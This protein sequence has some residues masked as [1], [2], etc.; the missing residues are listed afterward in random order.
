MKTVPEN[1]TGYL[2]NDY[3]AWTVSWNVTPPVY[4][5]AS[6][7]LAKHRHPN[8]TDTATLWNIAATEYEEAAISFFILT[9]RSVK[10]TRPHCAGYVRNGVVDSSG[11]GS[12]LKNCSQGFYGYPAWTWWG[13]ST[14][15]EGIREQN[16]ALM[17]LWNE[18]TALYPTTYLPYMSNVDAPL[19]V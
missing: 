15:E 11:S 13:N 6:F 18:Q 8:V 1:F 9:L 4:Q 12:H 17:S 3:E 7:E 14:V 5:N 16:D 19:S 10:K 2:V